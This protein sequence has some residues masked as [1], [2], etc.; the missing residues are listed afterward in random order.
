MAKK[1]NEY[2]N[3]SKKEQE[4]LNLIE[5]LGIY[6]LR[7]LAR[8]F[9]DNSPTTLKRS[10]HIKIVMD[11]IIAGEDLKP[12]PL[13]QGRPYKELSNIDGI[14]AELSSV[15]GKDYTMHNNQFNV[16]T[17]KIVKFCQPQEEIVNKHLNPINV[18]GVLQE[19]DKNSFYFINQNEERKIFVEKGFDYRLK[20][21]DYI[22]GTAIVMNDANEYILSALQSINFQLSSQYQATENKYV[23][24]TPTSTLNFNGESIL[25]GSR[26]LIPC[27][28]FLELKGLNSLVD[29]LKKEG[30][31]VIALVSNAMPEDMERLN[32]L[33]FDNLFI[34]KY[35]MPPS[36]VFEI[37]TNFIANITRL[38]EQ[39]MKLALFVEDICTL[40]NSIDFSNKS[41]SPVGHS[42]ISLDIVKKLVLL[43]KASQ[44]GAHTTMFTTQDDSDM[45]DPMYVSSVYKVSKKLAI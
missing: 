6:E 21:G 12:I 14:L 5:S 11:K 39:G 45:F 10:D 20:A 9:G 1:L 31:K 24:S 15:A 33:N 22:V 16:Y 25:L 42:E 29:K 43:A 23:L 34:S 32:S 40:A 41:N 2:K 37:T 4:C 3:L 13:R 7:A 30:I 36:K 35:D 38:Q 28:K 18:R 44:T 26:Y 27:K 8:V 17:P 19:K